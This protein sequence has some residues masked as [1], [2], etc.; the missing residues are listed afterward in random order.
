M[1]LRED[2]VAAPRE[3]QQIK[4]KTPVGKFTLAKLQQLAAP[5]ASPLPSKIL[6]ELARQLEERHVNNLQVM[7]M[8]A[9]AGVV[10]SRKDQAKFASREFPVLYK[11]V[12]FIKTRK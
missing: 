6:L 4:H 11:V 2:A 12:P 10:F 3:S 8:D 5:R 1:C 9:H 7:L